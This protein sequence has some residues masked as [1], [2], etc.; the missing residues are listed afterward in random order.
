VLLPAYSD[1]LAYDLGLIE[2]ALPLDEA[3]R[4]FRINDRAARYADDP[5]FSR[6]IREMD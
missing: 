1:E 5:A 4:R 6:R 2:T 3:R